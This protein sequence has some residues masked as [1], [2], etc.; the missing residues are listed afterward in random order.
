MS[1]SSSPLYPNNPTITPTPSCLP[2]PPLLEIPPPSQDP[3]Y[4]Q[5]N[6]QHR[7]P[8]SPISTGVPEKPPRQSSP[9]QR[10]L[11][12]SSFNLGEARV[13]FKQHL[14]PPL[15][16]APP[17][18]REPAADAAARVIAAPGRKPTSSL[19]ANNCLTSTSATLLLPSTADS[20]GSKSGH[21][22]GACAT[23]LSEHV[24]SVPV[25]GEE[26]SLPTTLEVLG[27]G[28]LILEYVSDDEIPPVCSDPAKDIHGANYHNDQSNKDC[29]A[30]GAAHNQHEELESVYLDLVTEDDRAA[31]ATVSR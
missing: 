27:G 17:Y 8:H 29:S 11:S 5:Q 31:L 1:N 25:C 12:P 22:G 28:D 3:Q 15:P 21:N 7:P 18:Q 10:L 26:A 24:V 19:S 14:S 20:P 16:P 23:V 13:F 6:P 9:N 30:S 4:P 2:P